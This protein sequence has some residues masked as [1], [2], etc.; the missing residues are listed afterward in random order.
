VEH[1]AQNIRTITS[2]RTLKAGAKHPRASP[3]LTEPVHHVSRRRREMPENSTRDKP[4][5]PGT[6]ASAT[7]HNA[8]QPPAGTAGAATAG[9]DRRTAMGGKIDK[10][11]GRIKEA[12]GCSQI[13]IACRKRGSGIRRW[14]K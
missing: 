12:V 7:R 5:Q 2:H 8:A 10:I 3:E 13:T 14:E 9:H 4:M 1:D 6:T 11:K